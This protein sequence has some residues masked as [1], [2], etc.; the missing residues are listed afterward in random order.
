MGPA[1]TVSAD[2]LVDLAHSQVAQ[3]LHLDG[4]LPLEHLNGVSFVV[5]LFNKREF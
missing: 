5:H 3:P 1:R 4:R 2:L